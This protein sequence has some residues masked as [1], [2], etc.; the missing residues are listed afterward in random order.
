MMRDR[1]IL[2]TSTDPEEIMDAQ[3]RMREAMGLNREAED[4][5]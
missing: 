3:L 5:K 1:E 2:Q 4:E